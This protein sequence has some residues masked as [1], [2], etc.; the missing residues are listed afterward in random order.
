MLL[1]TVSFLGQSA[2]KSGSGP[3]PFSALVLG[4]SQEDAQEFLVHALDRLHEEML[5]QDTEEKTSVDD[6]NDEGWEEVGKKGR[7]V[8]ARKTEFKPSC[9]STIFGGLIRSELKRPNQKPSVTREVS[10]H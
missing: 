10:Y 2:V 8:V 9:L 7:S 5:S 1:T 3:D 4:G 6:E